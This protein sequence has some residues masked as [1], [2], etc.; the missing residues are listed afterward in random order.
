MQMTPLVSQ[1]VVIAATG[2]GLTGALDPAGTL[3]QTPELR[4]YRATSEPQ[5]LLAGMEAA[6][7]P[8]ATIAW[9]EP[10]FTTGFR[11]L[12]GTDGL[13]VRFDAT[14]P[15]PWHTYTRRD[16]PLWEEEVVEVFIDPDG[17]GRNYAEVEISPANIVCDLLMLRGAP[18]IQGDL[19]WDFPGLQTVVHAWDSEP[20][21][22]T[23][24]ALLPWAGF[25]ALP[26]TEVTLRLRAGDRWRFNVYRIKRPHGPDEPRRDLVL[27][28][29]SPVPAESFHVPEVF[30]PMVFE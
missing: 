11:A 22:W 1:L 29:W 3:S 20:G 7:S 30:R 26:D 8:A 19:S 15:A 10:P 2:L 4:V 24:I 28:A 5:Q 18:D 6:W 21:G 25:A 9:G 13:W 23:A 12:R 17:D 16:D 27:A 14:D